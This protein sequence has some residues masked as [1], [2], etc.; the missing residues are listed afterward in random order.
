MS[1]RL[2]VICL[3]AAG[4]LVIV[5]AVIAGSAGLFAPLTQPPTIP[6]AP[7]RYAQALAAVD[8]EN[9]TY[10]ATVNLEITVGSNVYTQQTEET[11]TIA[12]AEGG[13]LQ[14]MKEQTATYGTHQVRTTESY[15]GATLYLT[16]QGCSFRSELDADTYRSRYLPPVLITPELYSQVSGYQERGNQVIEYTGATQAEPWMSTEASVTEAAGTV[17]LGK[18]GALS[19]STYTVTYPI[20]NGSVRYEVSC[21]LLPQ[22]GEVVF[23]ENPDAYTSIDH[24]DAPIMLERAYGYLLETVGITATY[25]DTTLCQAFGDL[26]RQQ[27]DLQLMETDTLSAN[28]KTVI[29]NS[30]TGKEGSETEQTKEE[31]F[32]DGVYSVCISGGAWEARTDVDATAAKT[33]FQDILVSTIML[34]E[35]VT[36]A[37]CEETQGQLTLH[38]TANEEFAQMMRTNACV[39]LYQDAEILNSQ[40]QSYS[41]DSVTCYL[42]VDATTGLP[43]ASGLHYGGTYTI[44]DLPYPLT[45]TAEQTY[46]HQ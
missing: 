6:D 2:W 18:D 43:L 13:A 30:N 22:S 28:V 21:E 38:F 3:S 8:P 5:G 27:T 35:Y 23:P 36:Q 29:K 40:S 24:P 34:P 19:K 1:K 9:V 42:T 46:V 4:A 15:D 17:I 25:T 31:R 41:T 37:T 26:R 12:T 33:M 32:A 11:V 14:G 10:R 16:T 7:D 39:A 45:F 20:E 44:N